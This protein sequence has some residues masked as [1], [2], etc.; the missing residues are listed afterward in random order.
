MVAADAG[1][2]EVR[3]LWAGDSPKAIRGVR[4][5]LRPSGKLIFFEHALSPDPNVRRWHE[6]WRPTHHWDPVTDKCTQ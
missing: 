5:V 6:W 2:G 1:L 3:G 4:R